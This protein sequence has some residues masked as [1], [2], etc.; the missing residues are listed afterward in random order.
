MFELETE[1]VPVEGQRL[2]LV[3]DHYTGNHDLH[4]AVLPGEAAAMTAVQDNSVLV[5]CHRMMC[6]AP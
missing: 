6:H 1:C 2:G 5:P 4:G 3:V